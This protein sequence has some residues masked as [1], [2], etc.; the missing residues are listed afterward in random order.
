MRC[1]AR[2]EE[3]KTSGICFRDQT[4][5][6][7]GENWDLLANFILLNPG[8]AIPLNS[9]DKTQYLRS[10]ALPFFV[11][12]DA[13]ENFFQFKYYNENKGEEWELKGVSLFLEESDRI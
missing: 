3:D 2:W 8:S 11:E 9:E 10:K 1:F 6:Q 13:G 7:F 4:I 12:P 5:L